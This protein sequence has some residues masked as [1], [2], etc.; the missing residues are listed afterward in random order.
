MN[1]RTPSPVESASR[2]MFRTFT[3]YFLLSALLQSK[4]LGSITSPDEY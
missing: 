2:P 1:L 4:T 3:G